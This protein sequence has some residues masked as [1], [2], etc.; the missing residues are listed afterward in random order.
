MDQR[1]PFG[2]HVCTPLCQDWSRE[3]RPQ[4]WALSRVL[5]LMPC[6]DTPVRLIKRFLPLVLSLFALAIP[7]TASATTFGAEVNSDFTNQSRGAWSQTQVVGNLNSLYKAGG[8]GGRAAS[9]WA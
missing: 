1:R 8:R 6:S 2:G 5:V 4:Q 7:A 3:C 9:N